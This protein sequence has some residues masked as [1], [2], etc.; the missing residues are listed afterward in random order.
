MA[1]NASDYVM[2]LEDWN[3]L[4]CI[5]HK[6]GYGLHSSGIGLHLRT[7]HKDCYDLALRQQIQRYAEQLQLV[8]PLDIVTPTNMPLPIPGLKVENGWQ[9]KECGRTGAREGGAMK[10]CRTKHGWTS[11]KG[12]HPEDYNC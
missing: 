8:G 5:H 7:Y 12:I 9:C 10:H 1:F 6:C 11:L 4:V 3:V 2:Y